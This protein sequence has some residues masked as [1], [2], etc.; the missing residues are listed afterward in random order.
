MLNHLKNL[1]NIPAPSGCEN[2]VVDYILKH[3]P[4]YCD[5]V[6]DALG[7]LIVNVK[8]KNKAKYKVQLDAHLDEVGVII[9]G[10]TQDGFLRFT[11]LG[12]I[13]SLALISKKVIIDNSVSGVICSKPVHMLTDEQKTAKPDIDELFI[14]IG[15][16][17]INEANKLVSPGSSG[18]F[19]PNFRIIE[20][21]IFSKAIDDRAGCAV[22]L[23][24]IN[25]YREY[26]YTVT[27]TTGEEIGLRGAKTATYSVNPDY[28][29]VV[30]STTAADVEGTEGNKRVCNLGE[31]VAISFMDRA[32][33]YDKQLYSAAFDIAK[34]NDIKAQ[35]KTMASGGNNAGSIHTSRSGVKTLALSLPCRYIHSSECVADVNDLIN[36]K[37]LTQKVLEELLKNDN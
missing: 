16:S 19:I 5:S 20:D 29:I 37:C 36:L 32:T 14:D 10:V 8:G 35:F 11:T 21:K 1:C 2:L 15:A 27:F 7:N 33:L 22:L 34:K 26:D 18:T 31:G 28:A 17:N 13:D 9:T 12:G 6:T 24:L 30:E 25:N 23:D 3:L 4:D